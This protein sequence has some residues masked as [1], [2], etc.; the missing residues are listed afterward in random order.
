V[1]H[2]VFAS[3]NTSLIAD[4]NQSASIQI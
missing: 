4:K 3:L 1:Q 2:L